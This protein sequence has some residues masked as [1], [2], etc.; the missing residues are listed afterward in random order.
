M[1]KSLA[2]LLSLLILLIIPFSV[3]VV[4]NAATTEPE[5]SIETVE[6]QKP[7]LHNASSAASILSQYIGF[8]K[9]VK[10]KFVKLR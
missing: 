2:F 10:L 8:I 1:K 9:N 4:A 5:I 7:A 3:P 6:A